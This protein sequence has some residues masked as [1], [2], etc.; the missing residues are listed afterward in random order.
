MP[1]NSNVG[2]LAY[3]PLAGGALTGKYT[4]PDYIAAKKGRF[5]LFPG[6]KLLCV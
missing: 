5:N 2:L 1:Q 4:N 6:Y 3:S